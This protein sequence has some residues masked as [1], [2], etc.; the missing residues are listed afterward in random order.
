MFNTRVDYIKCVAKV[1]AEVGI[2]LAN[3]WTDTF[4]PNY[5]SDAAQ[6]V[7][8]VNIV[9]HLPDGRVMYSFE[10]WGVDS[11]LCAN[12]PWGAWAQYIVRMDARNEATIARDGIDRMYQHM[13]KNK[14]GS[15][16][17][18]LFDSRARSKRNGR[19]T[20]GYG[21]AMGSH[22][23]DLR[24]TM[25]VRGSENGAVEFQ[26][27]GPKLRRLVEIVN[28]SATTMRTDDSPNLWLLLMQH[29]NADG[30]GE[31]ATLT[32]LDYNSIR[33]VL[34]DSQST[35]DEI[36]MTLT[37]IDSLL[38]TLSPEGIHSVLKSVQL[39]LF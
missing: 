30:M 25:Y 36:E 9:R 29:V 4:E 19:D 5:L 26:M 18:Q 12:L 6:H 35:E 3:Q 17:L 31:L 37:Q 20:G 22:K 15:R 34:A 16:N 11:N 23:S 10:A 1:Q 2:S 32:G 21:I 14:V 33:D 39:R 13:R 7:A 8:H 28:R 27:Q 24:M 38:D